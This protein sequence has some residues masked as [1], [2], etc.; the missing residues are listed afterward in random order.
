MKLIAGNGVNLPDLVDHADLII[1]HNLLIAASEED[2]DLLGKHIR[3]EIELSEEE[4][5]KL[6][7]KFRQAEIDA[8]RGFLQVA[9]P[10]YI[11]RFGRAGREKQIQH[12][13]T[14]EIGV[15]PSRI[16][17]IELLYAAELGDRMPDEVWKAHIIDNS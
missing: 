15:E 6:D 13:L 8:Y 9:D 7:A 3:K 4:K 2:M 14:D 10:G 11:V 16:K 12:M 5:A 1:L 17:T